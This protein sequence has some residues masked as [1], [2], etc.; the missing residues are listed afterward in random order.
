MLTKSIKVDYNIDMASSSLSINTILNQSQYDPGTRN[1]ISNELLSVVGR[2]TTLHPRPTQ[3]V[4]SRGNYAILEL[5]GT[6]PVP[7]KSVTYNIPISIQY[8]LGYPNAAPSFFVVPSTDMKISPS[9]FVSETGQANFEILKRWHN[10]CNTFQLIDEAI[11]NFSDRMPVFKRNNVSQASPSNQNYPG[12]VYTPPSSQLAY[13]GTSTYPPGH[14]GYPPS[15]PAYPGIS[16]SY[17][18][19]SQSKPGYP[20]VNPAY[21]P[22][23]SAYPAYNPNNS[24]YSPNNPSYNPAYPASNPPYN[25]SNPAY[26]PASAGLPQGGP[27]YIPVNTPSPRS[28]PFQS[29]KPKAYDIEK[30]TS[31]YQSTIQ[32]LTKEIEILKSEQQILDKNSKEIDSLISNFNEELENGKNKKVLLEASIKNTQDWISKSSNNTYTDLSEKELLEYK[33]RT[34]MEYLELYS[35]EKAIEASI[36]FLSDAL[37]KSILPGKDVISAIKHL[38]AD[39]FM[40]ARLKEKAENLAKSSN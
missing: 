20:G 4:T 36:L 2:Y 26:P 18:S 32:E 5:Y 11:K 14:P 25:P 23:N 21:P 6:I 31:T 1:Y 13:P 33:N 24:S 12:V 37:N 40:K 9:N 30:I 8:P 39:L 16:N 35:E 22:N 29:S 34:A 28:N 19:N 15:N 3:S 17:P 10:R 38:Y 7:F 27:S